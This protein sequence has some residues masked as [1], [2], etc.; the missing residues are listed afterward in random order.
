M[1]SQS[2]CTSERKV[3]QQ[4]LESKTG[5]FVIFDSEYMRQIRAL[6]ELD[7]GASI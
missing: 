4:D 1:N 6:Q 2:D 7:N 3:K 5:S